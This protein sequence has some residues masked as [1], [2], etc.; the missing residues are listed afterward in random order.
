MIEQID[1]EG[2]CSL[3]ASTSKPNPGPLDS[4][5]LVYRNEDHTSDRR[6]LHIFIKKKLKFVRMS[7]TGV[8]VILLAIAVVC[9]CQRTVEEEQVCCHHMGQAVHTR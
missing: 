4:H 2:R 7:C 1:L 8:N 6:S 9:V 5:E 3:Y